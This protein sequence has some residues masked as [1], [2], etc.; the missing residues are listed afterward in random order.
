MLNIKSL[1]R[2]L[3]YKLGF[4][5][6]LIIALVTTLAIKFELQWQLLLVVELGTIIFV[7][8]FSASVKQRVLRVFT[9]ATLYV[10][11]VAKGE[12]E[13]FNKPSFTE[14]K[15]AE[16][17]HYL[18][19]LAKTN[20][21][22]PVV[23]QNTKNNDIDIKS[24]QLP[25]AIFSI[26][27]NCLQQNTLFESQISCV[28]K[29]VNDLHISDIFNSPQ[30]LIFNTQSYN[31]I[32]QALS[33]PIEMQAQQCQLVLAFNVKNRITK[34]QADLW[35][36]LTDSIINK[37]LNHV[38]AIN[39]INQ[40]NS[41]YQLMPDVERLVDELQPYLTLFRKPSYQIED[42][43][44]KHYVEVVQSQ[45]S[46]LTIDYQFD[47][48]SVPFDKQALL[49]LLNLLITNAKEAGANKLKLVAYQH[50]QCQ[51]I[52]IIDNGKGFTNIKEAT[53]L[54]KSTKPSHSG[55]GLNL[56]KQ[57]INYHH[58]FIELHNNDNGGASVMM[59]IPTS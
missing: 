19:T 49:N 27:G 46:E 26:E 32:W 12:P 54:H 56:A 11:A 50:Q 23:P 30:Q 43:Q 5:S 29:S 2:F 44:L 16:F 13:L 18:T 20:I 3:T 45:H 7:F 51:V 42:C 36:E 41:D 10:D 57:I 25:A 40:L 24:C 48:D 53:K 28:A 14:G 37:V 31:D 15:V 39:A 17:H 21:S 47:I 1:E 38:T 9:R 6:F 52:E 59:I 4:I 55:L 58:G 33:V 8:W 22:T 34:N 35:K